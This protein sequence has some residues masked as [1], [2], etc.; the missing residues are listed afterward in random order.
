[1]NQVALVLAVFSFLSQIFGL[2]RDRLLASMIGPSANLDVYYAAFR[3][4]DFIYNSFGILFSVTVLI[5]FITEYLE[6]EKEKGHSGKLTNFLNSVFTV[7]MGGMAALSALL[8]VLMPLLTKLTAPGFVGAQQDQLVLYSRIMLLSPFLFG[9]SSLLS[10][11]AQVQKK[12]ISFAIAPLFYNLGILFGIVFFRQWF[13][14]IGVI[15]G[16]VLGALF[17]FLVQL[18]TLISLHKLPRFD[19][20]VDWSL[21]RRVMKL[22]L[23]RTLGSSLSNITFI[24]MGAMASL[25]AVGSISVFQFSYNIENTP[26]LIIGVSYATAAFPAMTRLFTENKR[27]E[28]LDIIYRTT[29]NIFFLAIPVSLMVIVLR[30]HIVR[31]L[32]GA[33]NFSWNDTRLVAASVAL[34][35]ISVVAQCLILLMVRA[36]Y[37]TGDTRTPLRINL[38]A[39]FVTVLST[40]G[41]LFLYKDVMMF[42]EFV[43][44]LMRVD[45]VGGATVIMLPLGFSIGQ[46]INAIMLWLAFHKKFKGSREANH[47]LGRN[48]YHMLGAGIIS[49]AAAY[50][51]LLVASKGVDQSHLLGILI[52]ATVAGVVGVGMYGIVLKALGNEDVSLFI[53]TIRSKFWKTKPTVVPQQQD[54]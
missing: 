31:V 26:L 39:V 53:A 20:N 1:M 54:L 44:S 12:F 19:F 2:V 52:Q 33:G 16:V 50:G 3:I 24:I 37:A 49:A 21:I 42:R 9:L 13:G 5:P 15:Y 51:T 27:K 11:F 10:S 14:M 35:S 22:S 45:G 18:P 30:A 29:R 28:L 40:I 34:F 43:N 17:Y 48:L 23:P 46:I 41:L 32:L 4:P 6:E 47:T 36:F 7:Y 8:I 25:L 38:V